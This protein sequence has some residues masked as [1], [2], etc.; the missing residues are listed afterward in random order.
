VS[1]WRMAIL[2]RVRP[3][4]VNCRYPS[5]AATDLIKLAF[6]STPPNQ[7]GFG[8]FDAGGVTDVFTLVQHC[9]INLPLVVR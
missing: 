5:G 8:D 9:T 2:Y 1:S 3:L 4:A 6:N 7:L